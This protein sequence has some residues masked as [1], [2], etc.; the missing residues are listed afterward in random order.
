MIAFIK[1]E[2]LN[3]EEL[4]NELIAAG[5]LISFDHEAVSAD[6]NSNLW[7]Q[8]DLKDKQKAETVV[9]AHNGTTVPLEPTIEEKLFSVGL[10]LNDLKTALGL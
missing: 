5:V 6:D 1:P 8:I 4:R 7:L 2:N 9:A 3:G 10:N